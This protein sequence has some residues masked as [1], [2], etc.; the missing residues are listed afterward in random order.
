M[1]LKRIVNRC[2]MKSLAELITA[3]PAELYDKIYNATFTAAPVVSTFDARYQPPACL[4][5]DRH[6]RRYTA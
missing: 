4:Q 3:L 6:S 1:I 5:V 2:A